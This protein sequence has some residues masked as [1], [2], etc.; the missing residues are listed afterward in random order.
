MKVCSW[1]FACFSL[2]LLSLTNPCYLG[3]S[4]PLGKCHAPSTPSCSATKCGAGAAACHIAISASSDGSK[5]IATALDKNGQPI[6]N[7][8]GEICVTPGKSLVF[9]MSALVKDPAIFSVS[10]GKQNPFTSSALRNK[11]VFLVGSTHAAGVPVPSTQA[12]VSTTDCF[13]FQVDYCVQGKACLHSDP[14]II[15]GP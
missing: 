13:G 2:V 3:A 14:K 5:A 10:F 12:T 6:P 7:A 15:I 4:D 9:E 11:D 1:L 8:A